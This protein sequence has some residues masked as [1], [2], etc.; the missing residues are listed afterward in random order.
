V[1]EQRKKIWIDRFQTYLFFRISL[2][3]ICYQVVLWGFIVLERDIFGGLEQMLGPVATAYGWVF[4]PLTVGVV[5][6]LFILDALRFAHRVVGPLVRFRKAITSVT[7]G[8]E[9]VLVTL[10]KG[11][12]LKEMEGEFNEMLR[13]L[14]QR[15]AVVIRTTAAKKDQVRPVSV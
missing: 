8:E 1:R 13:T 15:G 14:E 7:A 10:R 11:D 5:S 12:F 6:L 2:Y 9:L 3:F 4:L